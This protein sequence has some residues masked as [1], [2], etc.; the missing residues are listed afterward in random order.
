[1]ISTI[2]KNTVASD[3]HAIA[4]A[5]SVARKYVRH[6]LAS[7][8]PKFRLY[9]DKGRR[10]YRTFTIC[11]TCVASIVEIEA[12]ANKFLDACR[13]I[14]GPTLMG[15]LLD[16]TT[17]H[18]HL[19]HFDTTVEFDKEIGQIRFALNAIVEYGQ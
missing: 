3:P 18:P 19:Y 16:T 2:T 15:F 12:A 10:P 7:G 4:I 9:R 17:G 8:N 6:R 1:M 5:V 13:T 14:G 11:E